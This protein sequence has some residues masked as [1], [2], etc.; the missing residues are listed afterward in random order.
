M[1]K[2]YTHNNHKC[3]VR[4]CKNMAFELYKYCLKLCKF[5]NA[6]LNKITKPL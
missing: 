1:T 2:R 4:N 6:V 3:T 5:L